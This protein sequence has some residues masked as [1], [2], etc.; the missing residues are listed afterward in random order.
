LLVFREA[1]RFANDSFEAMP[2]DGVACLFSDDDCKPIAR[3]VVRFGV[4]N[5][6]SAGVA[7]LIG[8]DRFDVARVRQ[9]LVASESLIPHEVALLLLGL[10]L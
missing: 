8:E 1:E 4:E 7:S 6:E 3:G 5:D 2:D 9:S 10:A